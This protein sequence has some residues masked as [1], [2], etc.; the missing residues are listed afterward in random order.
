MPILSGLIMLF[1]VVL[2][3]LPLGTWAAPG[4]DCHIGVFFWHESEHD[5]QAFEGVQAG[6]KEAGKACRFDVQNAR[7]D[8]QS[9][10]GTFSR[11]KASRP[12]LIYSIGTGATLRAMQAL[13]ETPIVFTA[14]LNPVASGITASREGGRRNVA[15]TSHWVPR[16]E[17]LGFFRQVIPGMNRLGVLF[18]ADNPVST[19]EV[20]ETRRFL[21]APGSKFPFELV[22]E[23]VRG[24]EDIQAAFSRLLGGGIDALWIPHDRLVS[25]SMEKLRPQLSKHRLPVLLSS[26]ETPE[27]ADDMTLAGHVVDYRLLGRKSVPL[28]LK[29]LGGA[30]AEALPIGTLA[31]R[32]RFLNL[33]TAKAIGFDIPVDLLVNIDV[34]IR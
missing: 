23:P 2:G 18:T 24:P 25:R 15:G 17:M 12:D 19:M 10:A 7:G 28:A 13:P 34:L 16:E 22:A 27:V 1:F 30:R 5:T 31:S 4:G 3:W 33:R 9:A 14:V 20:A 21:G 8:A 11:W 26:T 32:R 29:I 6:F